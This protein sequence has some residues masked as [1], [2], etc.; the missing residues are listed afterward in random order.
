MVSHGRITH[1][2]EEQHD[3]MSCLDTEIEFLQAL[4]DAGGKTKFIKKLG[5]K[6][7]G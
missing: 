5:E 2:I 7:N 4:R 1:P 3:C 6:T